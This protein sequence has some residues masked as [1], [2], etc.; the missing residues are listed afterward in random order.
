LIHNE[1]NSAW[2]PVSFEPKSSIELAIRM[3][4][5][6]KRIDSTKYSHKST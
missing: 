2:Y 3:N 5:F 4:D 1:I 6:Q